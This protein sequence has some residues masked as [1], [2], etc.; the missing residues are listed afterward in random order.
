MTVEALTPEDPP[1]IGPYRLLGRLGAGG[2]G[3]VFLGRSHSGRMVAVKI[4]HGE[5]AREPDFRRRFR[6]EVEAARRV[7]GM[8]TAPVLDSD[9]E[10]AVPWVATGYV[11]GPPLRQV[12]DSLNGPLAE[13]SVWALALGLARALTEIHGSGL[14]HRDLKP[15][16]VMVTLEGPKVIDFGIAR[17]V[18]AS[19]VTRTGAM[20]G[21]PGY[22]PPEQIRGEELTGAADVFALGAVLAYAAT[23]FDPFS[24]DGAQMHTILYRVMYEAPQLGPENGRLSGA[25]RELVTR[26]L[27]KDAQERP[28]LAEIAPL[29]E[30]RAGAEFWLPPGLTA[31]LGRD[32]ADLLAL[33]GPQ[34]D[35]PH[36]AWDLDTPGTPSFPRPSPYAPAV[37]GSQT[38][39]ASREF[40]RSTPPPQFGRDVSTPPAPSGPGR[41]RLP[42]VIGALAGALALAV[43][44]PLVVTNGGDGAEAPPEDDSPQDTGGGGE[45]SDAPLAHL[46]PQEVWDAGGITVHSSS[47]AW[48]VIYAEEGEEN[49]TGFEVDLAHAIGEQLGVEMTFVLTDDETDAAEAAVRHGR[50]TGAHIAMSGFVDRPD[51][52]EELEVDFVNHFMDGW[53]VMSDDPAYSGHMSELC[54]LSVTTYEGDMMEGVV[55]DNTEACPDPVEVVPFASRDN[56]AA[57]IRDGEAEAAVLLYSQA[58]Y[59]AGEHPETG[60][61]AVLAQEKRSARGIAVPRGQ[62]ELRDALRAAVG[63]LL[64]DGTYEELLERWHFPAAAIDEPTVNLGT[65]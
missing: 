29:A 4:V 16:N 43:V 35:G 28:S 61:R 46:V 26:C 42:Y 7:S 48:P 24:W 57:A 20:I 45:G 39:Y 25:L 23:G 2:M 58:A 6:A 64:E 55:A 60:L 12:V 15:S 50:D 13:H 18:D 33:D 27:A 11:V 41:R 56:M 30:E 10:S 5:L 62:E 19:V 31:R 1:A 22:M 44:I 9:T 51:D 40:E 3:Q 65:D 37:H 63:A 49:L 47:E 52:R 36:P 17:A 21:S 54:G 34:A 32:A 59:Y 8:W 38:T 14:I 53:G